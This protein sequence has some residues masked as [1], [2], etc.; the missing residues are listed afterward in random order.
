MEGSAD[1]TV[2]QSRAL[3]FVGGLKLHATLLVPLCPT[4]NISI[5]ALTQLTNNQLHFR[6]ERVVKA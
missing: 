1:H 2:V 5:W 6:T 4:L 3:A